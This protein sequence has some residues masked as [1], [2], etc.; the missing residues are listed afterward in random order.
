MEATSRKL[1]FGFYVCALSFS[2]ERLAYYAAKWGITVFAV[3]KVAEGGLGLTKG[4]GALLQS[5]LVAFTYI[6]PLIGG[7]IADRWISPRILVPVGELLMGAGYLVAWQATSKT[8]LILCIALVAI[9]TGFFKGVLSGVN[10]RQF[11]GED[12]LLIKVF[13]WQYSFVNIG[14]FCG[15]TF[16][17][18]IAL[19]YGYRSLFLACGI[20][21]VIDTLWWLFGVRFLKNDAGKKPFKVDNRSEETNETVEKTAEPLTLREKKRVAAIVIVTVFSGI[22]WLMWYMVYMPVYYEFGPAG[23][24]GKGWANWT[25]GNFTMPTAWFDSANGLFCIILCPIFASI[26]YKMSKRAKGDWS[27]W[28]K[29]AIGILLLGFCIICMVFAAMLA[30]EG[31]GTPVGIWIIILA[32]FS[33]TVGEVVFSP[34]GNAFINEYAPKQLLGTLLGIWPF[35]I[36]FAGLGYGPLYNFLERFSFVKAYGAV[37]V[38]ILICGFVMLA[39][40]KRFMRLVNDEDDK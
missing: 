6:T 12:Q 30:K 20:F 23:Q 22:F 16:L 24:G 33:M 13:S 38:I 19:K 25:I 37:A 10:G 26:W 4:E 2:F 34:L 27:M 15:T 17:S 32:A 3:L 8:S 18:L 40:D 9:G 29:T 31:K 36:F 14:S 5:W 28:K 1:P 11:E 7:W 39:F 35:V 21:M